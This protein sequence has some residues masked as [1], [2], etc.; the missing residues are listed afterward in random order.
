MGS[1]NPPGGNG[2]KLLLGADP[3]HG[4]ALRELVSMEPRRVPGGRAASIDVAADYTSRFTAAATGSR[5]LE[6]VW[7]CGNGA[8][9]AVI[10]A[11]VARLPGRQVLLNARVD[12]R[13]PAHHPD[14]AVAENLREPQSEVLAG[15]ADWGVAFDGDGDRIGVVDETGSLIWPDQLLLA[16]EVLA[17]RPGAAVVG[18]VNERLVMQEIA[19]RLADARAG[20]DP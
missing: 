10:V 16:T 3:V 15:R 5:S 6:V 19:A 2:F 11:L 7:D 13:L 17:E 18:D 4:R 12:G 8:T 14:P 20:G 9:G 1:H